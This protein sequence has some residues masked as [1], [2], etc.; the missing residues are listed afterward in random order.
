MITADIVRKL[1]DEKLGEGPIF[2]VDISVNVGN[3]ISIELDADAGVKVSIDDCVGVSRQVESNL[4]REQEDFSLEVSSAGL[5]Q[6]LKLG[7]QY[8]KNLGR[9][10]SVLLKDGVEKIGTLLNVGDGLT[11]QLPASKKQKLP[12]REETFG[13]DDIK[14]TKVRISFK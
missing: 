10:V 12:I 3:K 2:L 7:R 5:G 14:E 4:D 8:R 9:E 11:L 6:P 13:W 1:V